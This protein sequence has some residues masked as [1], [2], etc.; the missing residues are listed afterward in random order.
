MRVLLT[1]VATLNGKITM[2]DDPDVVGWT[3][4][5][6]QNHFKALKAEADVIIRSSVTYEIAKEQVKVPNQLQIVLTRN[7]DKYLDEEEKGV[8]EFTAESP[9]ELIARLKKMGFGTVLIA[10]GGNLSAQFFKEGLID[11]FYLTLEPKIFGQGKDMIDDII[12]EIN[13]TLVEAPQVLN[14][15]GTVLLKY[16]VN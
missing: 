5:E 3:S 7:P 6:D 15:Q 14:N 9:K 10:V 1:Y 11:E 16:K 8:L 12:M 2:S 13:L 4:R